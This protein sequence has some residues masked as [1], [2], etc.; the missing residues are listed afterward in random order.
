MSWMPI[1]IQ[2][3]EQFL[4]LYIKITTH[5]KVKGVKW[6]ESLTFLKLFPRFAIDDEMFQCK[7]IRSSKKLID[8]CVT[9][10]WLILPQ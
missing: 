1:S 5:F 8:I 10:E 6:K 4:K 2:N 7:C 3:L 9:C